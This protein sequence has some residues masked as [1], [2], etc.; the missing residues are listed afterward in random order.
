MKAKYIYISLA[1]LA[2]IAI[3]LYFYNKYNVAPQI[4]ISKIEVVD[5]DTNRFDI[6]SLKGQKVIVSFYAS[7][8]PNCLDELKEINA[9]KNSRLSDVTVLCITDESIEK[10]VA[11]QDKTQYPFTFV[12]LTNNFNTFGIFS[13]PT[14]YLL[15]TKGEVVYDKVGYIDWADESTCE[16]LKSLME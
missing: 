13:I 5:Q 4:D 3:G 9:I 1:I 8:C 15:N 6:T 11:F 2:A 16:H 12:T 14:T 7:W 10:L